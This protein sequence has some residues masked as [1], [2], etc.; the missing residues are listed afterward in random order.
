[1]KRLPR[2]ELSEDAR[3]AIEDFAAQMR[4]IKRIKDRHAA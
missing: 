3:A 1:V 2:D 4:E